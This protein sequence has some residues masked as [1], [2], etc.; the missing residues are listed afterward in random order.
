[1][2]VCSVDSLYALDV[3]VASLLYVCL[4]E[5][6]AAAA[7]D[8]ATLEELLASGARVDGADVRTQSP[9]LSTAVRSL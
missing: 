2:C 3:A 4:Y 8:A 6:D 7:G 5:E 9:A 1:M